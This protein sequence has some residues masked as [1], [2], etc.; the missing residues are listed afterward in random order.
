MKEPLS[1][2]EV[3]AL[4]EKLPVE[5]LAKLIGALSKFLHERYGKWTDLRIEEVES[6]LRDSLFSMP[7]VTGV[8]IDSNRC[9]EYLDFTVLCENV[10]TERVSRQEL[11]RKNTALHVARCVPSWLLSCRAMARVVAVAL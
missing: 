5:Q 7:R 4:A 10:T 1:Y 11:I 6:T 9:L 3:F 8:F 2:N